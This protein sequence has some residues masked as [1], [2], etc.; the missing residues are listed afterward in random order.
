MD[1]LHS[2]AGEMR[3]G[4]EKSA[5]RAGVE[6]ANLD[7]LSLK[8][9]VYNHLLGSSGPPLPVLPSERECR[10]G[11]WY[12]GDG[13]QNIQQLAHF[14]EIERPHT[15]VH[16]EGIAAMRSFNAGALETAVQHLGEMEEANLAVM[17]IVTEV[18]SAF[19]RRQASS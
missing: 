17:R 6:L 4:I 13:S 9:I 8:F 1:V 5:F 15:A 11:K 3:R 7:E 14:R 18:T 19:E 16:N 12:Y 10:F 2:L